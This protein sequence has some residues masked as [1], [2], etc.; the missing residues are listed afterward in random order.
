LSLFDGQ[1]CQKLSLAKHYNYVMI[2]PAVIDHRG[3]IKVDEVDG[4]SPVERAAAT[5]VPDPR[6][7]IDPVADVQVARRVRRV[8]S[9]RLKDKKKLDRVMALS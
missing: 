9:G 2:V 6:M 8:F 5:F 7:G 1:S 3:F 4:R